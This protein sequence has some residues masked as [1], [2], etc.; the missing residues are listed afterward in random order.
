MRPLDS[1][2]LLPYLGEAY[3]WEQFFSPEESTVIIDRL[4]SEV[5]WKQEPIK[6]FGRTVMQPRL[7]ALQGDPSI[8]YGYSGIRMIPSPFSPTVLA[9]K[10]RISVLAETSF[11]HVLLNRYRDGKDSMGWHRDNERE[12][13]V[14]PVIASVSFG[15]SRAFH[16]RLYDTKDEKR[17]IHLSNG[18]LL[19][20]S[21]ATQHHWEHQLPKSAKVT[22]ERI[23]LTFR[24]ING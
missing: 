22:G 2:N 5:T 9:I 1:P 16:F 13:G 11:T 8:S 12:L 4:I 3:F 18:S 14:N 19:I 24:A 23:N 17:T 20:M 10:K 21:G 15:E 7:T 6:L